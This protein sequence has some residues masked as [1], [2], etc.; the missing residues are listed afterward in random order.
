MNYFKFIPIH[1]LTLAVLMFAA[2]CSQSS[3]PA[4]G[5]SSGSKSEVNA[6][7]PALTGTCDVATF[8]SAAWTQC[9]LD[10]FAATSENITAHADILT[11]VVTATASYQA[12]RLATVLAD[13]ERQ[14]NPNSTT[15]ASPIDPRLQGWAERG[16]LV[17]TVV[18]TSRSGATLS[19]HIWAT[20][21]GA[22][23]RPGI[24][25][26]NGSV[27]GFENTYWFLAQALAKSGFVV[28]TFDTQGEGMSDQFGEAP[29]QLEDAFAGT[30]GVGL[31]GPQ[32]G[33]GGNGLPFYDG[34]EDALDFFLSTPGNPYV[35]VPSR[36][37]GTSHAAKQAR[38]VASGLNNA[39][40]PLWNLLDPTRIGFTGHSYG[41]E[42][43]S[44][45]TQNDPRVTTGV[46]LD[47]LC[48]PVSPSPDEATS[49]STASVNTIGGALPA[50]AAYGLPPECFGAPAGPAPKITK[51]ELSLTSDYLLVPILYAAPPKPDDKSLGALE[52]EK[53]GVDTGS[54]VI[55]G[56]THYEFNDTPAV[57]P[58]SLRGIDL[59]TWYTT[60]WFIKYLLH[61]PK[62]DAM[63]LTSRWRDD[64]A[65]G[66]VDP[67]GD[68][69]LYS[70]HYRSWMNIG[71]DGGGRFNCRDLRRGCVGQVDPSKDGGLADYSFLAVDTAPDGP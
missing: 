18:Y 9:E 65:A 42:A 63:L 69:N 62:A 71:L 2:S 17:Q 56:G 25:I 26:I 39:Y 70:W 1:A 24:V 43:T 7:L 16:G 58:A 66:A 52:Y 53:S 44:W 31:L 32:A 23:K 28:M 48:I 15:V 41:A 13:P 5:S 30:P 55:R 11:G 61:D 21:S 64:A 37:S 12:A 46:A 10:N 60:A 34:G 27:I 50:P 54:I 67:A 38:R 8:P 14:P 36:T 20:R 6:P 68:A 22:A 45:L 47:D 51:P 35:P 59:V 57:L 19:G 33:L 29:D 3:S 49:I 4:D 40:N